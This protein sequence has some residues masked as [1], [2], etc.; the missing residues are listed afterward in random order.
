[1]PGPNLTKVCKKCNL[2]KELAYFYKDKGVKDGH[3]NQCRICD[4]EKSSKWN[5]SNPDAH[6]EHERNH[7]DHN[8]DI[9]KENKARHTKNNPEAIKN[10]YLK[11]TYGLSLEELN[12]LKALQDNKCAVCGKHETAIHANGNI[13]SLSIDHCHET[14]KVRGL[15]CNNCNTAEGLLKG[16]SSIIRKLADYVDKHKQAKDMVKYTDER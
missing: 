7:R 4:I 8:P 2:E 9:V 3:R 6:A 16:N 14:G 10:T 15:L 1:M 11:C 12:L 5:K 13:K